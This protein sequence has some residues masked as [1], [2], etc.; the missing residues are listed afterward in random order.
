MLFLSGSVLWWQ[1]QA[2]FMH[3]S[4]GVVYFRN[5]LCLALMGGLAWWYLRR[6]QDVLTGA[7]AYVAVYA[8]AMGLVVYSLSESHLSITTLFLLVPP[9]ERC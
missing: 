6:L 2:W 4:D 1:A 5:V 9:S 8:L 7:I 3:V